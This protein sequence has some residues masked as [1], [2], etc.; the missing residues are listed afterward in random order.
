MFSN[1]SSMQLTVENVGP[2]FKEL[3][4]LYREKKDAIQKRLADFRQV[5]QWSD[6]DVFAELSFCLLTPQSSA[7]LCWEAVTALKTQSLLLKGQRKD[8]E[9]HLGKIRFGETKARYIVEAREMFTKNDMIQLKSRIE[10]FYNPFELREW[11][12]E[13]VKGLGY[14]E[15]S[16]F[17]RNIGLGE[18]FA[19]LDRHILRNLASYEVIPEVPASL[20]KKRYLEI[21]EKVRRFA[22]KIGIPMADLDLLF[23]SKETGWIFK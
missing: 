3:Q 16:H 22:A 13:N 2:D 4:E 9:P 10:S 14:K 18:E 20:T 8:I 15:A 1:S 21:E 17:L 11:F 7:K 5:M 19:I 6:D 12:V 23:W